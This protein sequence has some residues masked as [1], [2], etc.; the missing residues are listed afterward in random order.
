LTSLTRADR[1]R[2][3][4]AY[5]ALASLRAASRAGATGD[6][7]VTFGDTAAAKALFALRPNAFPPWDEPIRRAFGTA[8]ADGALFAR[9]LEATADAVRGAGARLG[10]RP[11]TLSALLGRPA[12][13]PAKLVDEY[14]WLRVT[15]GA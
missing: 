7:A 6:V 9:Y 5:A 11:R 15:R 4:P 3:E 10:T 1:L 13:S 12:S 14:L 8:R 2:I